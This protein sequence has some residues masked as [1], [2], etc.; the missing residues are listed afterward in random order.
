MKDK[1]LLFDKNGEIN[2]VYGFRALLDSFLMEDLEVYYKI[3][4]YYNELN[5]DLNELVELGYAEE[6]NG[7]KYDEIEIEKSLLLLTGEIVEN[8]GIR[9]LNKWTN[10]IDYD[11]RAKKPKLR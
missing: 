11:W 8:F 4:K 10:E 7:S 2:E 3:N 6:I 5:K 1:V 9:R